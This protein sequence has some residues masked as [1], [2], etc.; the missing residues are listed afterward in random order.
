MP[1]TYDALNSL[2]VARIIQALQ[3]YTL[4]RGFARKPKGELIQHCLGLPPH[5][6]T[7]LEEACRSRLPAPTTTRGSQEEERLRVRMNT[8]TVAQVLEA[9]RPNE[10][11]GRLS[12]DPKASIIDYCLTLPLEARA[13]IEVAIT[14]REEN[15][16][17]GRRGTMERRRAARAAQLIEEQEEAAFNTRDFSQ[18]LSLPTAEEERQLVRDYL[19]ITGNAALDRKVCAA[20]ARKR[21]A[22]DCKLL[23]LDSV[24]N[25]AALA[26]FE[27]VSGQF[28]YN[29]MLLEEAALV[30]DGA[31][32]NAWFCSHCV[33]AL[34]KGKCPRLALANGQWI[35]DPPEEL[36]SLTMSEQLLIARAFPR[37]YVYKLYLKGNFDRS[38]PDGLQRG[39]RGNATAYAMNTEEI[40][41]MINGNH[42]PHTPAILPSLL[43]V[44]VIGRQRV[45]A[46][47]MRRAF[48]IRRE[49]VRRALVWLRNH[50][51]LYS[52][53]VINDN[54]LR[55]LP[56]DDVPREVS[57]TAR[58]QADATDAIREAESYLPDTSQPIDVRLSD[59][60][61]EVEGK[62]TEL[63]V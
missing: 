39:M 26:P 7:R 58:A 14:E 63:C 20:C 9:I 59:N 40:A 55:L 35:G 3:P 41:G 5:V 36:T 44:C 47:W 31:S 45:P 24:P 46:D 4:P 56:V 6:L 54:A 61:M 17:A 60:S 23:P 25:P 48:A 27:T 10:L 12:R 22:H 13:R 15:R 30:R 1:L 38:N 21:N 32:S 11:P 18:F 8:L 28:L 62:Q 53:I 37:C 52:N 42:L 50:N 29:G 51:P 57:V 43:A 2:T 49:H 34:E 33:G 16:R 19:R